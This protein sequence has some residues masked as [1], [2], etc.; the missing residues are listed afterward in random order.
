MKRN[1]I[2]ICIIALLA[3]ACKPEPEPGVDPN[4]GETNDTT[5]TVVKKY[6]VKEYYHHTPNKPR[7][8]IEWNEDFSKIT[9][10]TTNL[11]DYFQLDYNFEYFGNDSLYVVVSKPEHSAGLVYYTNYTCFFDKLGRISKINYY[12][13]SVI[14]LSQKYKYDSSGKLTSIVDE[15]NNT[16]YRFVWEGDNVCEIYVIPSGE[17]MNCYGDFSEHIHP[18]Y[19]IPYML[20]DVDSYCFWY[21]TTPLWKKWYRHTPYNYH[22]FTYHDFDEDGYVSCSYWIDENGEKKGIVNYEYE[23]STNNNDKTNTKLQ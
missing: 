10:I 7:R 3:T 20:P 5:E 8:L 6:L 19:T 23:K 17:L 15:E 14:W 9:H 11:N 12:I 16:G 18:E 21:L 2:W 4:G 13:D 1:L 22:E